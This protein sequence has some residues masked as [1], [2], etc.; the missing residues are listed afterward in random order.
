MYHTFPHLASRGRVRDCSRARVASRR[1]LFESRESLRCQNSTSF[2]PQK[3]FLGRSPNSFPAHC[4]GGLE[5]FGLLLQFWLFVFRVASTGGLY[6]GLNYVL[7]FHR[8]LTLPGY[9]ARSASRA[10][11]TRAQGE[12]CDATWLNALQTKG[13]ESCV[14]RRFSG[15]GA[16]GRSPDISADPEGCR[17]V[18]VSLRFGESLGV[19]VS[20]GGAGAGGAEEYQG[21]LRGG[22]HFCWYVPHF[23]PPGLPGAS[24]G[25]LEGP[26]GIPEVT[27]RVPGVP[28]V[29]KFDLL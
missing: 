7:S 11:T 22:L 18:W 16:W 29:R 19:L 5:G 25:L 1:S 17:G 12:R 8:I 2:D 23:P 9:E 6:L 26:G 24:P 15:V 13:R 14:A 28:S 10:R 27:F 4:R 21:D 3:S 20:I